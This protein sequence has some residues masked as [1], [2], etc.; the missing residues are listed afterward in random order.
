MLFQDSTRIVHTD[1]KLDTDPYGKPAL[2]YTHKDGVAE[3]PKTSK[4]AFRRFWKAPE[5]RFV[6]SERNDEPLIQIPLSQQFIEP[7]TIQPEIQSLS[8]PI[9]NQGKPAGIK[10]IKHFRPI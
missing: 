6:Q 5:F 1:R 10:T 3:L 8:V 7:V 2:I 9:I 4:N